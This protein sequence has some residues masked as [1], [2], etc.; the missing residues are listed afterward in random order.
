MLSINLNR[1][2]SFSV[3]WLLLTSIVVPQDSFAQSSR[4]TT[5]AVLDSFAYK[6][7]VLASR[8]PNKLLEAAAYLRRHYSD[9]DRALLI[10]QNLTGL[11]LSNTGRPDSAKA[12][13]LVVSKKLSNAGDK[14]YLAHTYNYL[15]IVYFRSGALLEAGTY[16]DKAIA[17]FTA[18]GKKT[19]GFSAY[20]NRAGIYSVTGNSKKAL[21][22]MRS[23]LQEQGLTSGQR[24]T[25]LLN[26]SNAE[27]DQNIDSAYRLG[28]LALEAFSKAGETRGVAN[29]QMAL[30]S[31]AIGENDASKALYHYEK[32]NEIYQRLNIRIYQWDVLAGRLQA[33]IM[34]RQL[35]N[36]ALLVHEIETLYPAGNGLTAQQQSQMYQLRGRYL[37]LTGHHE[38][39]AAL[40]EKALSLRDSVY[41]ATNI[42]Q[43]MELETI[44]QTE[45]KNA[46]ILQLKALNQSQ[47]QV[48]L[49]VI[50][51][52][53]TALLALLGLLMY[54]KEKERKKQVLLQREQERREQ[55]LRKKEL[56][57]ELLKEKLEK[58][59][60][61]LVNQSLT[62]S[63]NS[64]FL[65]DLLE[66]VNETATNRSMA[67][68]QKWQLLQN[69][70]NRKL[71]GDSEW[72][73]FLQT[74]E[75][76]NDQFFASLNARHPDL[77]LNEKRL[78]ALSRIR[79]SNKEI[80]GVLHISPD[81]VKMARYRMKKKMNIPQEL[82]LDDYI[83]SL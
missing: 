14:R 7:P 65:E 50:L 29:T 57:E 82:D 48:N 24:A 20:N 13:Y 77:T 35:E 58:A 9:E 46:E 17:L 12:L 68:S 31:L 47:R 11:Y 2:I 53:S 25:V 27:A 36:A 3:V 55:E 44:Y 15:G 78:C 43:L 38:D 34:L 71:S 66:F 21:E 4:L 49:L 54:R 64:N 23:L 74:F 67:D 76:V 56:E 8:D 72:S 6:L 59:G 26:M 28:L 83:N 73:Q 10:A 19:E 32:A 1:V 60:R 39:G 81:S 70:L 80:A 61:Q 30:G 33:Y 5:S 79:M 40:L 62:V 18:L 42:S 63:E 51:S 45:R 52:G 22:T 37:I 69:R 75:Q 41:K 16:F